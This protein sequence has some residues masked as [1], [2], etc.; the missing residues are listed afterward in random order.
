MTDHERFMQ[1]VRNLDNRQTV[2][3]LRQVQRKNPHLVRVD[4]DG[5]L[6]R[7]IVQQIDPTFAVDFIYAAFFEEVAARL[8]GARA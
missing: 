4:V 1:S 6:V 3:I 8:R 7:E 2:A 5:D